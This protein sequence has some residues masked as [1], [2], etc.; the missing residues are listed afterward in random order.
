MKKYIK[1]WRGHFLKLSLA[2]I[3]FAAFSTIVF[4]QSPSPTPTPDNRS[5]GVQSTGSTTAS[6]T[7]PKSREAKPELVLQTGYNN[8]FGATR[9]FFCPDVSLLATATVRTS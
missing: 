8:F 2:M 5:I 9:I 1:S 4:G 6:Q 3:L 7:S